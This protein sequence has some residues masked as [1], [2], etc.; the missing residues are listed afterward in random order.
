[1]FICC[2]KKPECSIRV[3][4]YCSCLLNLVKGYSERALL[5]SGCIYNDC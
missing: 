3:W 2:Q 4:P 1:M 5:S